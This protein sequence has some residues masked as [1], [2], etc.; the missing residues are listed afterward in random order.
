MIEGER[1]YKHTKN[2]VDMIYD[3]SYPT[4]EEREVRPKEEHLVWLV[5]QVVK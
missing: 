3:Y 5:L 4:V 2:C 1:K